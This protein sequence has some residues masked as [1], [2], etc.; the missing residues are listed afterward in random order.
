MDLLDG[1]D[2]IP[3]GAFLRAA[4][5]DETADSEHP[6]APCYI[7][8]NHLAQVKLAL[9]ANDKERAYTSLNKAMGAYVVI[10]NALERIQNEA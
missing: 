8:A 1:D 6:L 3:V 2:D 9:M 4:G 7:C 5:G 10:S